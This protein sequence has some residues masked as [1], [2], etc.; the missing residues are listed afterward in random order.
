MES[1]FPADF[2][3]NNRARLRELFTEDA[4]IVLTSNGLLQ[5]NGDN[6]FPF[7]Q[8]SSFWYLTGIEEPDIV[9]VMDKGKEY[10]VV[11]SR[12]LGRAAFDGSIN[13]D[14]LRRRSGIATILNETDGWEQLVSQFKRA[15]RLATLAAAPRYI[16]QYG[17]YTNPARARLISLIKKHEP[18]IEILDLREH[19]AHMRMIK[20]PEELTAI[21]KAIDITVDGFKATTA[22]PALGKYGYEFE[23]EADLSRAFRRG[24]A[25]GHAFSP[26]VASGLRACTLHNVSNEG[27]LASGE[28]VVLDIGAEYNHYAADIT[29]T[30]AFG[31]ASKRQQAVHQAVV[32][33][34]DYALGLLKP[35]AILRD[36]EKQVEDFIGKQMRRLGL[37]KRVEH[38]AVRRF[39]PHATTHFMGLDVHDTGDYSQPLQA[40]MVL[41]CEPG[42][43][44]PEESIGIRIEDDVLITKTGNKVLTKRLP[45]TL[46]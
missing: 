43:Y 27:K 28:L 45:R 29:R 35:G 23:I 25:S 32:E 21:Q 41:T 8:D 24:G 40:G 19:L 37:I 13:D 44:I 10:L 20:Q 18:D 17:L 12:D 36:Y 2:F 3:V 39:Y 15:K 33:T 1:T 22:K 14:D 5:R 38:D 4:P 42:I 26:I 31:P 6:T 30:I 16:K 11:P 46:G 7:R 34:Q 9:L